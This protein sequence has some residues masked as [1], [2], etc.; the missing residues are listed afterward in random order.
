MLLV[1]KF[2]N[3]DRISPLAAVM[4]DFFQ[5]EYGGFERTRTEYKDLLANAGFQYI[6]FVRR[7]GYN[8]NDIILCR[9]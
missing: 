4:A 2:L 6:E 5:L 9:K 3:D 7:E 8:F 1:E